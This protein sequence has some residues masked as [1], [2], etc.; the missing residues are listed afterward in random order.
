[1]APSDFRRRKEVVPPWPLTGR[2]RSRTLF[3]PWKQA[4]NEEKSV[5]RVVVLN[6][7]R[8]VFKADTRLLVRRE[9]GRSTAGQYMDVLGRSLDAQAV[10]LIAM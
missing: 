9:V 3:G 8:M 10:V 6:K 1:M 5:G 7:I 4:Q 2:S